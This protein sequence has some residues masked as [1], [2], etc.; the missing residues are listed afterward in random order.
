MRLT[1]RNALGYLAAWHVVARVLGAIGFWKNNRILTIEKDA[2]APSDASRDVG[3]DYA[4]AADRAESAQTYETDKLGKVLKQTDRQQKGGG[5]RT[6]HNVLMFTDVYATCSYLLLGAHLADRYMTECWRGLSFWCYLL[7][8]RRAGNIDR[9][10]ETSFQDRSGTRPRHHAAHL[11]HTGAPPR[12]Q[13]LRVEHL[14]R[15][16]ED[17]VC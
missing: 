1:T 17:S 6:F 5:A 2:E 10:W 11:D 16:C 13:H 3:L 8:L 15:L 9:F 4:A 7:A 14:L 12:A